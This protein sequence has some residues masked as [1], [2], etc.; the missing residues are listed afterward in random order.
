MLAFMVF[1]YLVAGHNKFF[2]ALVSGFPFLVAGI[3]FMI[4]WKI[5]SKSA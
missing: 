5:L 4:S 2:A 3:L 1:S